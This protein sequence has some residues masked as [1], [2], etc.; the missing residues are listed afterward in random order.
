VGFRLKKA[1]CVVAGT[2]NMYIVQPAWLAKVGIIPQGIEVAIGS[3]LDEPGFR[4]LSPKL[5]S[6]WLITPSRIEVETENPEEDCGAKVAAV[7]AALPWTPLVALGNNAVY[8]APL[9]ELSVLPEI[10][11]S[12]PQVPEG[13]QLAQR[14]FHIGLSREERVTNLQLSITRE[15]IELSVNVHTELRN[16]DSDTA[17]A[18]ARRFLQDRRDGENLICQLFKA[19]VEYGNSNGQPA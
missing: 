18:A 5:P 19:Q 9:S 11:R 4:F 6:Q 10:L 17:Q 2:F 3:K 13:Y 8:S 7:L 12:V 14:S 1:T 15:E 16:R